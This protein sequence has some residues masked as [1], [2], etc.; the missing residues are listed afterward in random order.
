[1]RT[2][3]IHSLSR[4][5]LTFPH[6]R[7]RLH[8]VHEHLLHPRHR[9]ALRAHCCCTRRQADS[10]CL[11]S[12]DDF[13]HCQYCLGVRQDLHRYLVCIAG[14]RMTYPRM[15]LLS[16]RETLSK[17]AEVTNPIGH[18]NLRFSNIEVPREFTNLA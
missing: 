9:R 14:L 8:D 10:R 12:Q 6:S 16:H 2:S 7:L 18:I 17:P 1:M 15:N 3:V 11:G 13:P 4:C 5:L